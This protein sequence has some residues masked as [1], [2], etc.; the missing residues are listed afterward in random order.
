MK[1]ENRLLVTFQVLKTPFPKVEEFGY[2]PN[3][4]LIFQFLKKYFVLRWR[5]GRGMVASAATV[6]TADGVLPW[7]KANNICQYA[8]LQ[9]FAFLNLHMISA[10]TKRQIYC[11]YT[12]K[13]EDP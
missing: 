4:C 1:K 11:T 12:G 9:I 13:R 6:R 10:N 3:S 8:K 7:T 5:S 2:I